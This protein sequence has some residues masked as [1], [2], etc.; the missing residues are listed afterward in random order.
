MRKKIIIVSLLL[1]CSFLFAEN[2]TNRI[3]K[4]GVRLEL[5]EFAAPF[6]PNAGKVAVEVPLSLFI[7]DGIL[8]R[9]NTKIWYL[10]SSPFFIPD[11]FFEIGFVEELTIFQKNTSFIMVGLGSAFSQENKVTSIPL[12]TSFRWKWLPLDWFELQTSLEN[13]LY[14][15][16]D[17]IDIQLLSTFKPF[18]NGLLFQLGF[19]GSVAYGWTRQIFAYSYGPTVGLG[20]LF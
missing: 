1:L 20:Y 5:Q 8:S 19:K 15:E 17:I 16:G 3:S 6:I 2:V 18:E 13:L 9:T 14:A 12:I 10:A 7:N 4:N 11:P